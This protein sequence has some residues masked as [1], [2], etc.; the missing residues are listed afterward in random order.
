MV[1]VQ[2]IIK[3][4]WRSTGNACKRDFLFHHLSSFPGSAAGRY[5][6]ISLP[7]ALVT[8]KLDYD[9]IK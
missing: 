9:M 3:Y 7:L 4:T 6:H 1:N 8:I 2:S 5:Y